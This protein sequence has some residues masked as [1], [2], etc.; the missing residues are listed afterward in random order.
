MKRNVA[1]VSA[2][3]LVMSALS[4]ADFKYTESSKMTGGAL[5]GAMKFASVFSKDAKQANAPQVHSTS[6]KGNKLRR[7]EADGEIQIIDLDGKRFIHIDPKSKTYY[8]QTFQEMRESMAKA[9]E[10][11]KQQ[12]AKHQAEMKKQP[13]SNVKITPKVDVN[14]T[15]ATRQILG[16]DTKEVKTRIELQMESD[17]PKSQGK[18][19]S[20]VMN[21]DAWYA[22]SVPGYDEIKQF[23]LKMAKEMDWFPGEVMKGMAAGGAN[24]QVGMAELRKNTAKMNGIPMFQTIS[25]T[26]AGQGMEA[27]QAAAGQQQAPPPQAQPQQEEQPTSAK[28]AIAQGIAGKFGLGG[29]GKKKKQEPPPPPPSNT[30]QP[31]N[32]PPAASGTPGALMEMQVEVTSYSSAPLDKS[33]FDVPAG[34]A[35]A[36]KVEKTCEAEA[37]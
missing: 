26:L 35:Q 16:L 31:A 29:F 19:V 22:A 32:T 34:Y 15:G 10:C 13:A 25:M 24:M 36:P 3:T 8:V 11:M 9:Q 23:Y 5:M 33:L 30:Q 17:D 27:Q 28:E 14:E 18:Q 20:T 21:D 12:M 37:K 1:V 6:V 4:W 7:D 2:L